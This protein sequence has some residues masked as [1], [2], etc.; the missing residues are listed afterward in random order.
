MMNVSNRETNMKKLQSGF[1]LIELLIVIAV[2]AIL[3]AV[4]YP[5]YSDFVRRGHRAEARATMMKAANQLERRFTET[6]AYPLATQFP[7]LFGLPAATIVKSNTDNPAAGKYSIGYI[8]AAS[9]AGGPLDSYQLTAT[10]NNSGDVEC[11]ILGLNN[12]GTRSRSG[13]VWSVRDCWQR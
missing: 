1:T 13:S 11:G 2:I 10:E 5:N 3:A 8:P 4:A 12:L 6:A 9:V 7:L